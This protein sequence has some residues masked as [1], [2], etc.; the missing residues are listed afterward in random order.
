VINIFKNCQK[1]LRR[2]RL[3]I[4]YLNELI[5]LTQMT[6]INRNQLQAHETAIDQ[7]NWKTSEPY[8]RFREAAY[9]PWCAPEEEEKKDGAV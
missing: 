8:L 2:F 9:Q 5:S 1:K 4:H 7:L 6:I 3:W